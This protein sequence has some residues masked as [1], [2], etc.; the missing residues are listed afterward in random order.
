MQTDGLGFRPD[1]I[2][3]WS[4][5]KL[6]I[7]KKYAAAYSRIMVSKRFEHVYV[8]GFS[9]AGVHVSKATGDF[10]PGSPLNALA[11]DPPFREL[12][13]VDMNPGKAAW[14][15]E[16]VA[17]HSHVRVYEGDCN[18]VL[19]ERVLP[20]VRYDRYRRALCLLDPYGLHVSW[21]VMRLAGQL[22]TV[23]M[24]L[25]FPMMDMNQNVLWRNADAVDD[26]QAARMT[27]FWGDESWRDAAYA[28]PK[29]L[30]LGFLESAKEK[31][32]NLAVV[33]AFRNR[34]RTA[35]GFSYVPEP[36][37]MRMGVTKG[38]VIY[39][40]F[41]AAKKALA[42]DIVEDI[43][44]KY[45]RH[46]SARGQR[47]DHRVDGL[48]MEPT[49]GLHEDQPGLS[50]LLRR[51]DG[52][53]AASHGAAQLRGRLLPRAPRARAGDPV[54]VAAPP[55][56]L[57]Q[58]HERPFSPEGAHRLHPAGLRRDGPGRLAPVPGAH[59]TIP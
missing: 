59:E 51:T 28:E 57:R 1:A 24:F 58:L 27:S 17:D 26:R 12:H 38:P 32:D 8:D 39:Y 34:L 46:R 43:F 33:Q 10:I 41:F 6:D 29:Q 36:L 2:G 9:G 14:L 31:Q 23:D 18:H 48:N 45:G 49:D 19:L 15:R 44:N 7:I 50:A 47:L 22:G 20:T 56:H 53:P 21:D 4:E 11:V 25:N 42:A 5:V 16:A 30:T 13:L 54:P 55:E 52:A 40:L 35:A 37:P 3:P